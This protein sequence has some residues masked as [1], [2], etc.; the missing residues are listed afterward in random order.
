M[1]SGQAKDVRTY[2]LACAQG[3]QSHE[4]T[5]VSL[6]PSKQASKQNGARTLGRHTMMCDTW[7]CY[8]VG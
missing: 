7:T 3:T 8:L 6:H 4:Y 1:Y 5:Q 2:R